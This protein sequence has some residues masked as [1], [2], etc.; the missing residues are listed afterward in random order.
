MSSEFVDRVRIEVIAMAWP[1]KKKGQKK[2][3]KKGNRIVI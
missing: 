2:D 1:C 3:I